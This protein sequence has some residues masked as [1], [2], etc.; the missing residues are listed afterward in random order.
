M[1]RSAVAANATEY[2]GRECHGVPWPRMP[3][4]TVAA[5]DKLRRPWYRV[6]ELPVSGNTECGAIPQRSRHCNRG[7]LQQGAYQHPRGACPHPRGDDAPRPLPSKVEG[8]KARQDKRSGSQE[9]IPE[10][11]TLRGKRMAGDASYLLHP[12]FHI[13][14]EL[15]PK[16]CSGSWE[17]SVCRNLLC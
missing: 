1:P 5:I 11:N 7:F 2:R 16:D 9:T 4:S 14:C 17:I 3:R 15:R 13:P 10:T 12:P 6:F 8:E